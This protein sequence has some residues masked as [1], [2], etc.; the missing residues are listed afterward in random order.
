MDP[1]PQNGLSTKQRNR[2]DHDNCQT[3]Y[4]AVIS[5]I[6]K[7]FCRPLDLRLERASLVL[8]L[9]KENAMAKK[10]ATQAEVEQ[11]WDD[12]DSDTQM[13]DQLSPDD[14]DDGTEA[15]TSDL[16]GPTD[17]ELV[18]EDGDIIDGS[19]DDITDLEQQEE[20]TPDAVASD[21]GGDEET[22]VTAAVKAALAV[23]KKKVKEVPMAEK[24]SK[25]DHIRAEIEKRQKS[26]AS[27]R[28][29]DIIEALEGKGVVV[30]APQVSVMVKKATGGKTTAKAAGKSEKATIRA[31]S[32]VKKPPVKTSEKKAASATKAPATAGGLD[33]SQFN[34]LFDAAAFVEKCG[35]V[36]NAINALSAYERLTA[37]RG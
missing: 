30:T 37:A 28:P 23:A 22:P 16:D 9:Q 36:E 6:Q 21:V 34:A 7:L 5:G 14:S 31:A 13:T 4:R 27:M 10:R 8:D 1:V 19:E 12:E 35:S 15:D 3:T 24:M 2:A 20:E 32:A 25:A 17:D 11:V 33:K 29:R 18:D 26:G